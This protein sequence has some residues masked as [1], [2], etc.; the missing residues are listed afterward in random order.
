M[1]C[2]NVNPQIPRRNFEFSVNELSLQGKTLTYLQTPL[3]Q[4]RAKLT[5]EHLNK[6]H[7]WGIKGISYATYLPFE[8]ISGVSTKDTELAV[9]ELSKFFEY[10]PQAL[11]GNGTFGSVMEDAISDKV[12]LKQVYEIGL[13]LADKLSMSEQGKII[14]QAVLLISFTNEHIAFAMIKPDGF[15]KREEIIKDF[16]AAGFK[17]IYRKDKP[18]LDI[19]TLEQ[20]YAEHKGRKYFNPLLEYTSSGPVT[21]L[22]LEHAGEAWSILENWLVLQMDQ[23]KVL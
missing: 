4:R 21:V 8:N 13:E 5:F 3:Q 10:G 6:I 18:A 23:K 1:P 16:E 22:I 17:V 15:E 14:K 12:D 11:G 2:L 7:S 20:H 19:A 9:K